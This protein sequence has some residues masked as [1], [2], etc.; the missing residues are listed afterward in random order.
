MSN[1]PHIKSVLIKNFLS[2]IEQIKKSDKTVSKILLDTIK[3]DV[4]SVTG[5]NLRKIK[6]LVN[7]N[8]ID[9]LSPKDAR[10]ILYQPV[11]KDEEWRIGMVREIVDIRNQEASLQEFT[12]KE[13]EYILEYVCTT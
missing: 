11:P 13:L 8:S 4:N 6:H 12:W 10:S 7:K 9:E 2:F 5:A 1:V 3:Y